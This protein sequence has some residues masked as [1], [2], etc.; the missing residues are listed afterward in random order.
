MTE[1]TRRNFFIG[2]IASVFV[3]AVAV[4]FGT[5]KVSLKPFAVRGGS[6]IVEGSVTW[7]W[8]SSVRT[9]HEYSK[10]SLLQK[11]QRGTGLYLFTYGAGTPGSTKLWSSR[12]NSSS[13]SYKLYVAADSTNSSSLF[14]FQSITSISIITSSTSDTNATF[15]IYDGDTNTT[16]LVT[17]T[18]TSPGQTI[19]YTPSSRMTEFSINTTTDNKW[20][21]FSSVTVNYSCNPDGLPAEKTLSSISISGQTES[22]NVGDSFVF[23]G[24]VVAHY[25]DLTSADV[26]NLAEFSGYDMDVEGEQTITVSYTESGETKTETYVL[27]VYSASSETVIVGTYNYTSR[28]DHK[29]GKDWSGNMSL[30]FTADS[31]CVWSATRTGTKYGEFPQSQHTFYSKVY[32]DYEV[33]IVNEKLSI[34][35]SLDLTK[36]PHTAKGY[37]FRYD[38]GTLWDSWRAWSGTGLDFPI[39]GSFTSSASKNNSGLMETDKSELKINV[40]D[41]DQSYVRYDTFTFTKA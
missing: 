14:K 3:M 13:S 30:V 25:S 37:E 26:T 17:K 8:D 2:S 16:P 5:G 38:E 28:A 11:T 18:I 20:V 33:E 40:Y 39:D 36:G 34:H 31:K 19:T 23:G 32:F 6:E 24:S 1:K 12:T 21:E 29:D 35:L 7:T 27:T 41:K 15:Y 9:R 10:Y 22:L 4:L